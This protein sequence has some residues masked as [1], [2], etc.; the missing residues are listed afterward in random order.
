MLPFSSP[1]CPSQA[2]DRELSS[3]RSQPKPSDRPAA[4]STTTKCPTE[5]QN[6]KSAKKQ[7]QQKVL[8]NR[9]AWAGVGWW[10]LSPGAR[11]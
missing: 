6:E 8:M 2:L 5:R 11:G 1:D 3:S 4:E 10:T 9:E 7:P